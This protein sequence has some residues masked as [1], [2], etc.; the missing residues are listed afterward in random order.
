[1]FIDT[2]DRNIGLFLSGHK[3]EYAS[4]G[5]G[6][7]N[8]FSLGWIPFSLADLFHQEQHLDACDLIGT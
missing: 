8:T 7:I 3:N 6:E 1:M 5:T 2:L 4:E